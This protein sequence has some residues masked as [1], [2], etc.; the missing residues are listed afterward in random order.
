MRITKVSV[1]GESE[2]ALYLDV[3]TLTKDNWYIFEST[4]G[5]FL[6]YITSHSLP[7]VYIT[8]I[9]WPKNLEYIERDKCNFL[10]ARIVKRLII[11]V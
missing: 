1:N 11:E 4:K 3:T 8:D 7:S 10:R 6:G 5:K 2:L 9:N